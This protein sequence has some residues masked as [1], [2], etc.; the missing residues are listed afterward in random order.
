[1]RHAGCILALFLLAGCQE[2]RYLTWWPRRAD[3]EAR[4][5]DWHDPFPDE[6][7]GP[8]TKT[9]P[10]QFMEPR[11]DE[12]KNYDQRFLQSVHPTAGTQLA[13]GPQWQG[14]GT[15]GVAVGPPQPPPGPIAGIPNVE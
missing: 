11:T 13:P 5:Y 9:R 8:D 7:I 1:M 6:R 10:R 4:S 3:V 12:R 14:Y 15:P 2:T